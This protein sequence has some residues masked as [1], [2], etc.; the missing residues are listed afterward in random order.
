MRA[1]GEEFEEHITKHLK[2][3]IFEKKNQGGG[4]GSETTL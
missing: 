1:E 4:L 2:Q 3:G